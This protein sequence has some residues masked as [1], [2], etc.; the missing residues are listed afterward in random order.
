MVEFILSHPNVPF[1]VALGI[2]VALAILEVVTLLLGFAISG[3]VDHVMPDIDVDAD[4]DGIP[5]HPT[6][7][8]IAHWLHVGD[9]P[10]LA[11]FIVFLTGFGL[12]GWG[13]Q[14]AA[15]EYGG[16]VW[17]P[18]LAA[19]P[20]ALFGILSMRVVGAALVRIGIRDE[21]TAIS[22][23][24]LLGSTATITLGTARTGQPSQAKLKD[25]HGQTHYVLV[26]PLR[27]GEE[28]DHGSTVTLVQRNGPKYFVVGDGVDAL[29]ALETEDLPATPRQK[30]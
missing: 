1:T 30:A 26:E 18:W 17:S 20:A 23:E 7:S 8:A 10:A 16:R 22:A 29:L 15:L 4:F 2:M 12:S 9:A 5:D 3:I 28:F 14:Y 27:S 11:L 6:L 13:I 21:T 25:K 19:L 24:S